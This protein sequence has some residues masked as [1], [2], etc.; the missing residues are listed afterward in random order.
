MEVADIKQI[1]LL[2]TE[3]QFEKLSKLGDPLVKINE[4]IEWEI[5]R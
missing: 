4:L 1:N 3:I 2:E 5:F